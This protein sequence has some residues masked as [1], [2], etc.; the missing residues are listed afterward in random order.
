MKRNPALWLLLLLIPLSSLASLASTWTE[1][2][3]RPLLEAYLRCL[4]VEQITGQGGGLVR[5]VKES[6]GREAKA[7]LDGWAERVQGRIRTDL[8]Q[9]FGDKAR[10]QFEAF[11]ADFS[12]AESGNDAEFLKR[13]SSALGWNPSGDRSFKDLRIYGLENWLQ[14]DVKSGADLLGE[15]QTWLALQGKGQQVPP[16]TIWLTRSEPAKVASQPKLQPKPKP[17]NSLKDAEAAPPEMGPG[18]QESGSPLDKFATS[19]NDRR[20]KALEQAQ[21]GMQQVAGERDAWEQENG[22]KKLSE[23]QAEADNMKRQAEK[24][25]ATDQEALDQRKNSWSTKLKEVAA[26]T[27]SAGVGSFTGAVGTRAADEATRAIF[28]DH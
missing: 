15:I 8:N 13:I 19:R 28:K 3:A 7:S 24:L 14:Q 27:I 25:A 11:V 26:S 2:D 9:R 6:A 20:Q 18:D 17:K 22:A 23:A 5:G 21:A 10:S 16:L 12:T 1:S 4:L